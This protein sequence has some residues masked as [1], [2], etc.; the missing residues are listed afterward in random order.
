MART[1]AEQKIYLDNRKKY[2]RPQA[3]MFADQTP[4]T[5]SDGTKTFYI[6]QGYEMGESANNDDDFLIL[7]DHN[8]ASLDFTNTRIENRQRT[9]NGRMRSFF[10]ADKM[11]LSVSWNLI[12]S[13][14]FNQDPNFSNTGIAAGGTGTLS[15][16]TVDGG[17][18]GLD[19]LEWYEKHTGSF[20][21]FLAY[22]KHNNFAGSGATRD[23]NE[24]SNLAKY[25]Q[26]V[27]MFITDFSYNVQ[28]RGGS[29][30]DFWDISIK[31]EEV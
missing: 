25:N 23:S 5:Y 9:V 1:N 16:Y 27:E 14:G 31:L 22:D 12:P 18:G 6:P 26:V 20:W 2:K 21:V 30:Y 24:Y 13:R 19:I 7:S 10:V 17:A 4:T 3:I 15:Q 28:K 11:S 29:N 8:R